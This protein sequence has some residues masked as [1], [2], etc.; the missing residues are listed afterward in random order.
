MHCEALYGQ[1]FHKLLIRICLAFLPLQ[2]IAS[3]FLFTPAYQLDAVC[4]T[5]YRARTDPPIVHSSLEFR[6]PG[7]VWIRLPSIQ[8][9]TL[10][11]EP[12]F[13]AQKRLNKV[14]LC[15]RSREKQVE[16]EELQENTAPAF[17]D[18]TQVY[19]DSL[20]FCI[21]LCSFL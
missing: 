15:V 5:S 6:P 7:I 14:F 4:N 10:L 16:M 12:W 18:A 1:P 11:P 13:W 3:I 17:V 8:N 2:K 21:C 19:W 20:F 9:H